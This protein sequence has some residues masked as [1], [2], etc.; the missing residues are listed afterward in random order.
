MPRCCF[1]PAA[2]LQVRRAFQA[3]RP[4]PSSAASSGALGPRP[5]HRPDRRPPCPV[6]RRRAAFAASCASWGLRWGCRRRIHCR[7]CPASV[8][9]MPAWRVSVSVRVG[10]VRSSAG[11]CRFREGRRFRRPK[12]WVLAWQRQSWLRCSRRRERVGRMVWE[13]GLR[14]LVDV[15][16]VCLMCFPSL[17]LSVRAST[18]VRSSGAGAGRPLSDVIASS[19]DAPCELIFACRFSRRR[20]AC[21]CA[22]LSSGLSIFSSAK[23]CGV[24]DLVRFGRVG[25]FEQ[26]G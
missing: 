19:R 2:P 25:N 15:S 22:G 17:C 20:R 9:P 5:G 8:G 7:V 10:S 3:C 21:R 12:R 24:K 18:D 1:P 13:L 11:L 16:Y 23:C 4:H 6:V 14:K 26:G